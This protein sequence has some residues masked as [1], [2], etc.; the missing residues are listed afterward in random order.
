MRATGSPD[1]AAILLDLNETTLKLPDRLPACFAAL[2]IPQRNT[3]ALAA[4]AALAAMLAMVGLGWIMKPKPTPP[5]G[6]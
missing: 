1:N 4:F 5:N 6:S 2:K 3:P